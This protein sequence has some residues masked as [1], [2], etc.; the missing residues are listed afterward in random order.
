MLAVSVQAEESEEG[1]PRA[2]L[3]AVNSLV[4]SGLGCDGEPLR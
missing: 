4:N 2:E 1:L 3:L